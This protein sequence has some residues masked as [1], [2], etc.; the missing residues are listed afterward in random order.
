[1]REER[2]S[3]RHR[4]LHYFRFR[5]DHLSR[6]TVRPRPQR[7]LLWQQWTMG[8]RRREGNFAP[9]PRAR[10]G[11][12][13]QLFAPAPAE[14]VTTPKSLRETVRDYVKI[15]KALAAIQLTGRGDGQNPA[16][17][18]EPV[19]YD[20]MSRCWAVALGGGGRLAQMDQCIDIIRCGPTSRCA[21][22]IL[23]NAPRQRCPVRTA[24]IG[25]IRSCFKRNKRSAFESA[26]FRAIERIAI[27]C[28]KRP[29]AGRGANHTGPTRP[30]SMA[31][32]AGQGGA[33]PCITANARPCPAWWRGSVG[34]EDWPAAGGQRAQ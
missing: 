3:P 9:A 24:L 10:H 25:P 29:R 28:R 14:P 34:C 21:S 23:A 32:P 2:G 26:C 4:P 5:L 33:S 11:T 18:I 30:C 1:M 16:C 20:R 6:T 12:P 27:S 22:P 17:A 8:K 31:P 15:R 19:P 7:S 13:A